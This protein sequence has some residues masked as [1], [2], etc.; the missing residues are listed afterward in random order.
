MVGAGCVSFAINQMKIIF[1]WKQTSNNK[2]NMSLLEVHEFFFSVEWIVHR[3][4]IWWSSKYVVF[5][6]RQQFGFIIIIYC[7]ILSFFFFVKLRSVK[8]S[9]CVYFKSSSKYI[10]NR[11]IID[12]IFFCS[13]NNI[14]IFFLIWFRF[15]CIKMLIA[16][17]IK[18]FR[19]QSIPHSNGWMYTLMY[20]YTN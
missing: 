5:P 19:I 11:N 10:W 2:K 6:I 15:G 16:H 17:K 3:R 14:I 18:K 7:S 12:F 20:R 4:W 13:Q 8:L 9:Q 1:P